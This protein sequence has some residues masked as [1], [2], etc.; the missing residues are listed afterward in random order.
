MNETWPRG[1][2]TK[3]GF[4]ERDQIGVIREEDMGES[5]YAKAQGRIRGRFV[6]RQTILVLGTQGSQDE[7]GQEGQWRASRLEGGIWTCCKMGMGAIMDSWAR[8]EQDEYGIL[9]GLLKLWC[10]EGT[11]RTG[12]Q[13]DELAGYCGNCWCFKSSP[14]VLLP[15]PPELVNYW[16][17]RL[18]KKTDGDNNVNFFTEKVDRKKHYLTL[19]P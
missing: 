6:Q 13:K 17:I 1:T 3:K 8:K 19:S 14:Y 18:R 9:R 7:R 12:H 5:V 10:I 11:R 16:E 4:R 15:S 2:E